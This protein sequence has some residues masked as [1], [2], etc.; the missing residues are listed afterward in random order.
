MKN[1]TIDYYKNSRQE[2]LPFIPLKAK[3]LLEVGMGSGYFAALLK[4][5]RDIEIWGLEINRELAM[6]AQNKVD[7]LIE[8]SYED[9]V[10]E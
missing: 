7:V 4:S 3:I 6:A 8:K 5:K 2:V 10:E 9:A 1:N